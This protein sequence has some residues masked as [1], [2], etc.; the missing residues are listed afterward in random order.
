MSVYV[1]GGELLAIWLV[2]LNFAC[3][4]SLAQ[5]VFVL[6]YFYLGIFSL[7]IWF[8]FGW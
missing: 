1:G 3:V 4:F 6:Y 5:S 8:I 7:L 2:E